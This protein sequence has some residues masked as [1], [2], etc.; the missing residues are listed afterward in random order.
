MIYRVMWFGS[1]LTPLPPLFRLQVV[2]HSQSS[3]VLSL[4]EITDGR[5][6]GGGRGARSYDPRES[7]AL[8][9]SF[10]A[11]CIKLSWKNLL[12]GSAVDGVRV[13][14]NSM[15]I[16]YSRILNRLQNFIS[17]LLQGALKLTE[18]EFN[19][20]ERVFVNLLHSG[21]KTFSFV[22]PFWSGVVPNSSPFTVSVLS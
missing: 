18:I 12:L 13:K 10:N 3:Y 11:L 22:Q 7:L 5:G 19:C 2:S 8:Y 21:Y 16:D 1:S 6:A 4:V 9:K 14:K 15:M 20:F 17:H